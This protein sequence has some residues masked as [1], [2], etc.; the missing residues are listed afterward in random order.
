MRPRMTTHAF[1]CDPQGQPIP[2]VTF[3][4]PSDFGRRRARTEVKHHARK[5]GYAYT[6][7]TFAHR[8]PSA[9]APVFRDCSPGRK[10]RGFTLIELMIVVA[11]LAILA[12]I[13]FP[14]YQSWDC[15]RQG[16]TDCEPPARRTPPKYRDVCIN[17]VMFVETGSGANSNYALVQIIDGHGRGVP[18]G[19]QEVER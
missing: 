17:G 19:A 7:V 2:L 8:S 15:K 16:R 6:L 11:I 10:Q 3:S 5:S 9:P 14:F 1:Y 18:C 12:A 13:A 4:C